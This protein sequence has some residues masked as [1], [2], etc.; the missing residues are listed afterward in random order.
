MGNIDSV[1]FGQGL[2]A[3]AEMGVVGRSQQ[4]PEN[5]PSLQSDDKPIELVINAF[6]VVGRLF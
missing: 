4:R 3:G 5:G 1:L 2:T 6:V